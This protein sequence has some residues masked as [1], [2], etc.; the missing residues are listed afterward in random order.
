MVGMV[1]RFGR[2]SGHGTFIDDGSISI[3]SNVALSLG[4]SVRAL[5]GRADQKNRPSGVLSRDAKCADLP[6]FTVID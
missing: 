5:L 2:A 1:E 3:K 4:D 6:T